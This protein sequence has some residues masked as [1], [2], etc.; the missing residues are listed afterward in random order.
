MTDIVESGKRSV[1]LQKLNLFLS[2]TMYPV[3]EDLE[4]KGKAR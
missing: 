3:R 2:A 1:D 4:I